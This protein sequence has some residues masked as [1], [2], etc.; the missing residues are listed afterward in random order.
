M[1][2]MVRQHCI[3]TQASKP[4]SAN[5]D[6]FNGGRAT[7]T[8]S[9]ESFHMELKRCFFRPEHA[10]MHACSKARRHPHRQADDA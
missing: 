3:A 7:G 9:N 4:G 10:P 5:N 8:T 6:A 1:R 2:S